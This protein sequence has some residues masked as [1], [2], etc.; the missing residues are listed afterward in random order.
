MTLWKLDVDARLFEALAADPPRW[1]QNLLG[2]ED[3]WADVRK[4]NKINI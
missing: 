2:E 4:G 3:I 1:W